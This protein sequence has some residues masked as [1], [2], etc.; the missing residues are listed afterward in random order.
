MR[1]LEL[2]DGSVVLGRGRVEPLPDQPRLP[3][4]GLYLGRPARAELVPPWPV[5]WLPWRDFGIPTDAVLAADTLEAHADLARE[6]QLLEITCRGG[7]G[8]TGTALASLVTRSGL[9]PEAALAWV[10]AHYHPR[11]VETPAQRRW[12]SWFAERGRAPR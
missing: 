1:Q 7:I 12:I 2:P 3:D 6:G 4:L 8:R 10:R 9:G 11:A 5:T